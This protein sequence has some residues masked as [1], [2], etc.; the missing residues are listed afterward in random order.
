M[1]ELEVSTAKGDVVVCIDCAKLFTVAFFNQVICAECYAK[2]DRNH[3]P[4]ELWKDQNKAKDLRR[5][6]KQSRDKQLKEGRTMRQRS[7]KGKNFGEIPTCSRCHET[8][9]LNPCRDCANG[10]ELLEYPPPEIDETWLEMNQRQH[11]EQ[12]SLALEDDDEDESEKHRKIKPGSKT[13]A[14]MHAWAAAH[15][16]LVPR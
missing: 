6:M 3:V 7:F 1:P 16:D 11:A 9:A 5:F 4:L 14:S 13:P 2:D 8:S 10:K 15:P 12:R